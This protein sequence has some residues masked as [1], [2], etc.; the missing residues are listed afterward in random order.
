MASK[1]KAKLPRIGSKLRLD[2]SQGRDFKE[3]AKYQKRRQARP[4]TKIQW[5]FSH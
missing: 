4:M 5:R 1:A 3:G 2:W